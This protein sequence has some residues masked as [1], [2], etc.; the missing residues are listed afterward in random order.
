[1]R[2][3][4]QDSTELP[5]QR[6][7]IQDLQDFIRI[8][9]E[10]ITLERSIIGIKQGTKEETAIS[11]EKLE[12]IDRFQKDVTSYIEERTQGIESAEILEIK[13]K[14]IEAASTAALL[15]KNERLEDIDRQNRQALMELQQLE[16]QILTTLGPFFETSIYRAENAYYASV[17]AKEM[18]GRQVSSVNGIQYE[19]ELHFVHDSLKVEDFRELT[20][21]VWAKSGILSREEK[22]KKMDVSGFHIMS[23]EYEEN[24]VRTVLQDKDAEH[25]FKISA[26]EKALLIMH[27]DHDITGDEK[28]AALIDNEALYMFMGKLKEFFTKSVEFRRLKKVLLDGK[29]AVEEN[30]VFDCLKII[31]GIYGKLVRECIERGYTK[32]EVTIKMEEPG[33]VRTEKYISKSEASGELSSIGS[34]GTELARILGVSEA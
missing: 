20:L 1:M 22:A 19:F 13:E 16:T 11:Q 23:I 17:E 34:E 29:N 32:G 10:A 28:L 31:A 4:F 21:P 7:F 25:M 15:K 9:K 8:S 26:D 30:T 14:T 18:K 33:S 6:D 3:T 12:E 2:Y 27:G 24:N 5:V